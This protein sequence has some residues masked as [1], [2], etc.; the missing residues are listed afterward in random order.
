MFQTLNLGRVSA[1]LK[2]PRDNPVGI[3]L[4]IRLR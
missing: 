3:V 1:V 4:K 2:S